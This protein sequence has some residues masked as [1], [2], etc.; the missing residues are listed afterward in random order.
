MQH[1]KTDKYNCLI[2]SILQFYKNKK[3][4]QARKSTCKRE[5]KVVIL[6]SN[7]VKTRITNHLTKIIKHFLI[8]EKEIPFYYLCS[9][10]MY[11]MFGEER[12]R[13]S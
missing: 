12:D 8:Y 5:K 7:L 9:T 4:M 10:W 13:E 11:R 3:L 1:T 6:S 2:Y